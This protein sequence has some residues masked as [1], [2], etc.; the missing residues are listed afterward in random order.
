[1]AYNPPPNAQANLIPP[2]PPPLPSPP[3]PQP[4][5]PPPPPSSQ[6]SFPPQRPLPRP[7]P[8]KG[9]NPVPLIIGI[10]VVVLIIIG[11][12]IFVVVRN[13]SKSAPTPPPPTGGF[14]S[15]TYDDGYGS[16][17]S[18]SS[19]GTGSSGSSGTTPPPPDF[20]P[21]KQS[22]GDLVGQINAGV[23]GSGLSSS[24]GDCGKKSIFSS[25]FRDKEPKDESSKLKSMEIPLSNGNPC[26]CF[27]WC[28]SR[29]DCM[30]FKYT[31][32]FSSSKDK[33][34]FMSAKL[35]SG[36]F[37]TDTNKIYFQRP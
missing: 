20:G 30:G 6:P 34:Y 26:P 28:G 17:G 18:G 24:D 23:G 31:P 12:I 37:R 10:V 16:G 8:K 36:D 22:A 11:I 9:F 25:I 3:I 32:K 35:S 1:M 5:F 19:G 2:P 15:P 14:N 21:V 7:P 29:N 4:S 13:K 33:C 27:Q